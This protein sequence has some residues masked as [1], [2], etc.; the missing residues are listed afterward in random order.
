MI[1]THLKQ[2]LKTL[3]NNKWR[4]F[5]T[6][7]GIIIGV[8][9]VLTTISLGEG[10]KKDISDQIKGF[11]S[12][13][14][15]V[16]PGQS[17]QRDSQGEISNIDIFSVFNNSATLS[18]NDLEAVS[19][20]EAI[21]QV[22]PLATVNGTVSYDGQTYSRGNVIATTNTFSSILNQKT[23][24]GEFLTE[25]DEGKKFAVIGKNIAENLFKENVPVG[26]SIE[27]RGEK[28][29][30]KGVL[31]KFQNTPFSFG[32]NYNDSVLIPYVTGKSISEG[33]SQIFQ[34]MAKPTDPSKADEAK[35]QI[36]ENLKK[37]RGSDTDFSVLNQED[38]LTVV[39]DILGV[40]TS[41]VAAVAA[42]S[43]LV[44]GIGVMNI[45]IV[46]VT[47]RT[48]EIGIRKAVGATNK[49]ILNQ[50][51]VEA[52]VLSSVGGVIGVV[53]SLIINTILLVFTD[54]NPV[55]SL[56][57]MIIAVVVALI[58]GVIFG[59]APALKASRK[60]PIDALRYQ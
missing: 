54:Q 14:I 36:A 50:F 18:D 49:Q 59:V 5:L 30:V 42:I 6:M 27:L 56:P 17:I 29:I 9:S 2:S 10:V 33:S 53:L 31:E 32:A 48:R 3:R 23:E 26:K 51:F 20:A 21:D 40:I 16:R 38:T 46:S 37:T 22:A 19:N 24:F 15:V 13:L 57:M 11:G 12:D 58:V 28:Y 35:K 47:E 45:M 4:S 52:V 41:L 43:L 34:I 55:I 7:L 44:G 60:H 1:A 39:D 25:N 8:A